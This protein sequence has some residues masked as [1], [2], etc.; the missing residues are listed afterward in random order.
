MILPLNTFMKKCSINK[1][2]IFKDG[3]NDYKKTLNELNNNEH[4]KRDNNNNN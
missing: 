2:S 3:K 4:T 1:Q